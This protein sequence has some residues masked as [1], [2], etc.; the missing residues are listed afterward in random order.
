MK[1]Q[2]A[3]ILIRPLAQKDI[4]PIRVILKSVDWEDQFL[5]EQKIN[6]GEVCVA[7][8]NDVVVGYIHF[9]HLNWNKLSYLHNLVVSADYRRLGVAKQLIIHAEEASQMRGNRGLFL[10]TKIDNKIGR[11]FYKALGYAENDKTLAYYDSGVDGITYL[12]IFE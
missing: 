11:D 4:D 12:K 7:V 2:K 5:D 10:D 3:R 9:Q 6:G 1:P 8:I